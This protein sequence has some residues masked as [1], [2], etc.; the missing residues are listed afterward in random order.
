MTTFNHVWEACCEMNVYIQQV[1][2]N[3][4][5]FGYNLHK[6]NIESFGDIPEQD[7]SE[8]KS[9]IPKIRKQSQ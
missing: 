8:G 6:F 5:V 1:F 9:T 2:P 3:S 7:E 4:D